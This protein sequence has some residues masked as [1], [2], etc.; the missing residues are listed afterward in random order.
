V[1]LASLKYCVAFLFFILFSMSC[2]GICFITSAEGAS[3]SGSHRFRSG[4]G[5][6]TTWSWEA[7]SFRTKIGVV[8]VAF[9]TYL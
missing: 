5:I 6:A 9:D 2:L 7:M 1:A 8:A 4:I 3:G